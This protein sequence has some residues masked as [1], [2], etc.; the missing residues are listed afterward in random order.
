VNVS[1]EG[2]PCQRLRLGVGALLFVLFEITIGH[3]LPPVLTGMIFALGL[4]S[5]ISAHLA[6]FDWRDKAKLRILQEAM[7]HRRG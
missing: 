2:W 3:S 6:I 7:A 5:M 4:G 1:E